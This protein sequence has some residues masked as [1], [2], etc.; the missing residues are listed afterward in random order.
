MRESLSL[1]YLLKSSLKSSL[2]IVAMR[3]GNAHL[4]ASPKTSDKLTFSVSSS[5]P[6][7]DD[8]VGQGEGRDIVTSESIGSSIFVSTFNP[9]SLAPFPPF[10][11]SF[12]DA[13]QLSD[14][15]YELRT[16]RI[17]RIRNVS[18]N[19][20]R[21]RIGRTFYRN[22]TRDTSKHSI[23]GASKEKQLAHVFSTFIC[24]F[25]LPQTLPERR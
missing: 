21:M 24:T 19:N 11:P 12:P 2:S 18:S 1:K 5:T 23:D 13:I 6:L 20:S 10:P 14:L 25:L 7:S 17:C 9:F 15:I 16:K 22:A 4:A 8:V 3:E